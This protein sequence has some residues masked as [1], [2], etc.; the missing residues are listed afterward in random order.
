M[1]EFDKLDPLSRLLKYVAGS[2]LPRFLRRSCARKFRRRNLGR[3][4]LSTTNQGCNLVTRIGDNVDIE[5]ALT[6]RF[7]PHITS[8]ILQIAK[9][10]G[11]GHFV[12]V[13]CHIGYYTTMVARACPEI[14]ITAI[15]ANPVMIARCRE[16]L[17]LNSRSAEVI[18]VGVG[19][20]HSE[21][22][23]QT[24]LKSPSLGTFGEP[25]PEVLDVEPIRV[26]VVPL[27]DLIDDI[28]GEILLLKMDV[29]GFE[30]HA[31]SSLRPD[32]VVKVNN[33]IIEFSD[34]RLQ[35]CGQSRN[36]F[37]S[38]KW[39]ACFDLKLIAE[40]GPPRPIA[41]LSE[42]PGGDQNIWLSRKGT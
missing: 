11:K 22:I 5:I 31:L 26:S 10:R 42:V 9:A 39:I 38:L 16:N 35:Q 41:S 21:M 4:I 7:E 29:E 15:D 14:T 17:E 6:G 20:S 32:Q 33:M 28:D 3:R 36:D 2:P 40:Q 1:I 27:A 34:L 19:A 12:D 37:N 30:F 18:N 25:P 8:V 24:S 13:G 23:F